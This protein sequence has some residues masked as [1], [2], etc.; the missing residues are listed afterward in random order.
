MQKLNSAIY[1]ILYIS[2]VYWLKLYI[3]SETDSG[4]DFLKYLPTFNFPNRQYKYNYLVL[5]MEIGG[6]SE[7]ILNLNSVKLKY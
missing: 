3:Y 7:G 6:R 1:S 2:T 5:S 4:F